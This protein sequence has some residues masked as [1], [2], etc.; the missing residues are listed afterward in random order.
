MNKWITP[1]V[2][3]AIGFGLFNEHVREAFMHQPQW[4][5]I[6]EASIAYVVIG[7]LNGIDVAAKIRAHYGRGSFVADPD[8]IAG[9]MAAIGW[10]IHWSIVKPLMGIY[11]MAGKLSESRFQQV[12]AKRDAK[13]NTA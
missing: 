12:R 10:P 1:A 9:T 4:L 8:G 2:L 11:S 5:V 3:T 13:E 6:V 7:F